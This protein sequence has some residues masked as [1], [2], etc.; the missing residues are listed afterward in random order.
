MSRTIV[1]GPKTVMTISARWAYSG[2]GTTLYDFRARWRAAEML[3]TPTMYVFL[4]PA[5]AGQE[6][7]FERWRFSETGEG[8]SNGDTGSVA[9]FNSTTSN[10]SEPHLSMTV[11]VKDPYLGLDLLSGSCNKNKKE[12]F[13]GGLGMVL[14][15]NGK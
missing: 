11:N 2:G 14:T 6:Y 13:V 4:A 8:F 5:G 1:V 9:T 3:C 7:A 15:A 10:G 12:A